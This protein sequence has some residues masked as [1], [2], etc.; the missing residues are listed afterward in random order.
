[1]PSMYD[2]PARVIP[3]IKGAQLVMRWTPH[4]D[5][6]AMIL[7]W[8]PSPKAG[9]TRLIYL[10]FRTVIEGTNIVWAY[11]RYCTSFTMSRN[12]ELPANMRFSHEEAGRG[13]YD[14]SE[15]NDFERLIRELVAFLNDAVAPHGEQ[16]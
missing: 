2:I 12:R 11:A 14:L 13:E 10:R 6:P 16:V 4:E 5:G 8:K 7:D 1:M 3:Q 9:A 15:T